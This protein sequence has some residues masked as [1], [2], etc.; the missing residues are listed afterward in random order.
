MLFRARLLIASISFILAL[1]FARAET[2]P[3]QSEAVAN[4]DEP[5]RWT[6]SPTLVSQYLFRGVRL[7]GASFQ[8][9]LEYTK[10]RAVLGL[11]TSTTLRDHQGGDS[12]PEL[13]LYGAY[14]FSAGEN[15]EFVPGFYLYTYPDA[16]RS[17]GL[18]SATL[19]PSLAAIFSAWGVQ[20]TP[21][22]YYDLMLK[23]PT[24]EITAAMAWPL[25]KLGTE[26]DF[27]ATVGTFRSTDVA[28]A[29]DPKVKNWGD[30][31]L[32][33]VSVPVQVGLHS[34]L[35]AGFTYSE[36]HSNYYKQGSLP[37][38]PNGSAGRHGAVSLSYSVSF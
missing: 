23:G 38:E 5:G 34:K 37:R 25:T 12:D 28:A 9:S 7:A 35:I 1:A 32:V 16:Q 21:K 29:T 6:L 4:A 14:T 22:L 15:L 8:P 10:G 26:L 30:Y 3:V 18:Y 17:N 20:F 36:G 33:G 24:A 27:V 19:E 11:W 31:W 2:T 13:D